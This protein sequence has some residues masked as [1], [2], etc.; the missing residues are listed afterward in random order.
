MGAEGFRKD[1]ASRIS[2]GTEGNKAFPMDGLVAGARLGV[3]SNH[4]GCQIGGGVLALLAVWK[5]PGVDNAAI[6][7]LMAVSQDV[8]P[9]GNVMLCGDAAV[10]GGAVVHQGQ[11]LGALSGSEGAVMGL[12]TVPARWR[13][14]CST[15]C[16]RNRTT[17][18][19]HGGS[20]R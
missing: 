4:G 17:T 15:R 10:R 16:R 12:F 5:D 11:Q 18:G 14:R 1:V 20:C 6:E 8:H 9:S 2:K 7:N 13:G 3:K 19:R